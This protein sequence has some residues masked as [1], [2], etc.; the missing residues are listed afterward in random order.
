MKANVGGADKWLRIAVGVALI[1]WAAMGGPAWAW[2]GVVPLLTGLF[3][4]CPLYA[5][6]G[7]STCKTRS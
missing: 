3:N 1:A 7:M 2:I 6:L 5:M 4:F